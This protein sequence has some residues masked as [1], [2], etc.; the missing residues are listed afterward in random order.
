MKRIISIVLVL[1]LLSGCTKMG[2]DLSSSLNS[3]ESTTTNIA[4]NT[5]SIEDLTDNNSVDGTANSVSSEDVISSQITPLP[6]N[7]SDISNASSVQQNTSDT[8]KVESGDTNINE[9]EVFS[10][11][12]RTDYIYNQAGYCSDG[13]Y[14]YYGGSV[15][16]IYDTVTGKNTYLENNVSNLYIYNGYLT[17]KIGL[18]NATNKIFIYN[19][20][21]KERKVIDG[22]FGID[23]AFVYGD[24]IYVK[25]EDSERGST[26]QRSSIKSDVVNWEIIVNN[27][28]KN[29]ETVGKYLFGNGGE[30]KQMFRLDLST[31]EV[32][33]YNNGLILKESGHLQSNNWIITNQGI[34]DVG[35]NSIKYANENCDIVGNVGVK[36]DIRFVDWKECIVVDLL[37]LKTGE[38]VNKSIKLEAGNPRGNISGSAFALKGSTYNGLYFNNIF[39]KYSTNN[40]VLNFETFIT[41][42]DFFNEKM[43]GAYSLGNYKFGCMCVLD[44]YY[45]YLSAD[46][47]YKSPLKDMNQKIKLS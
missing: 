21:N 41:P 42:V 35:S 38:R 36:F 40:D 12:L 43:T 23:A 15:C 27:V 24:Y 16:N 33:N 26:V 9:C 1:L 6:E 28:D 10:D 45:Y 29:F 18:N 47:V 13:R 19:L 22:L 32:L 31:G 34:F 7:T 20:S 39:L 4:D 17:G 11:L 37:N 2:N 8:S 46:A 5:T 44:G 14:I 3:T 30:S 25:N